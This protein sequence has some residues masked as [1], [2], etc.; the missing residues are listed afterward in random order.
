MVTP[1]LPDIIKEVVS[2]VNII[3]STKRVDPFNVFFESGIYTQVGK[4]RFNN[5]D[6]NNEDP[7]VWFVMPFGNDRGRDFAVY[8]E[9]TFQLIIAMF[10]DPKYTQEQRDS[11]VIKPRLMMIY[12][13]LINQISSEPQLRT[14]LINQMRHSWHVKP[15]WGGGDVNGPDNKNLFNNFIDAIQIPDLQVKINYPK[16]CP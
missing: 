9:N 7:F 3:M 4:D 1:Y 14:P 6:I 8:S 12:E 15:Y 16:N 10:T 5:P 13:E 11:M 2:R